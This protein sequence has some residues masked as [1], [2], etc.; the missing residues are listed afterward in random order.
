MLYFCRDE[1]V[2]I[3]SVGD[4]DLKSCYCGGRFKNHD[5]R[6]SPKFP[7]D[8]TSIWKLKISCQYV[9]FAQT[10]DIWLKSAFEW[11]RGVLLSTGRKRS[12]VRQCLEGEILL[13]Q[14][15]T[16]MLYK[17]EHEWSSP[18]PAYRQAGT[19]PPSE[20]RSLAALD[21]GGKGQGP[22]CIG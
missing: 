11:K 7:L 16:S 22:D 20:G 1:T 18:T 3:N 19:P 5:F 6:R 17:K 4:Y 14:L 10:E 8:G 21:T 13:N 15:L 12:L 2:F 9:H